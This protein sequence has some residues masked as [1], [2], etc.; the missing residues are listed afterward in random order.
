M[1]KKHAV[2]PQG[3]DQWWTGDKRLR[4]FR[5]EK[6]RLASLTNDLGGIKELSYQRLTLARRAIRIG[7]RLDALDL[8]FDQGG[9]QEQPSYAG[10]A[11]LEL[12]LY[13]ALGLSRVP[14]QVGLQATL[15]EAQEAVDSTSPLKEE[16]L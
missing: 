9:S 13:R 10:L 4:D 11:T 1:A 2:P 16:S 6:A 3:T 15:L 8:A 7:M 5:E 12:N 14:K